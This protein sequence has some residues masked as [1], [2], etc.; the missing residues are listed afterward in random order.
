MIYLHLFDTVSAYTEERLNNYEEPW[1]SLTEENDEVNYNKSEREKLLG[2]ELTFDVT[3][4]GTIYWTLNCQDSTLIPQYQKTIEFKLNDGEWFPIV[5]ATEG[6]PIQVVSGDTIQFRGDNPRYHFSSGDDVYSSFS[7]TTCQFSVKGNIMSLIDSDG[8]ESL[9]AFTENDALAL[10]FAFCTGLTSAEKLILPA[11]GLTNNCYFY[12][13]AYDT[14]LTVGPQLPATVMAS[15]CYEGMFLYDSSLVSAP[16]L[17]ATTLASSCYRN[18]FSGCSSLVSVPDELPAN[19]LADSCYEEMFAGCTS[20]IKVPELPG[21]GMARPA[22]PGCYKNM[23]SGC[24]AI[25]KAPSLPCTLLSSECYYGMFRNCVSLVTPPELPAPR[26]TAS[27]YKEMFQGC[28]SLTTAPE[29]PAT[30][31]TNYC[32][33]HMFA[34]CTNLTT[35]PELPTKSFDS[36]TQYCY[37]GMFK[38]CTSLTTAPELPAT[39]LTSYCYYQMFSGCTSL[40]TSPQAPITLPAATLVEGCYDYMF[41]GC[42]NV[43]EIIC[44]ATTNSAALMP[45]NNWLYGV[46][47]TGTFWDITGSIRWA[48]NASGI[49]AGWTE[50]H[51]NIID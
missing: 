3:S 6:A 14:S 25:T 31:M 11:T 15:N 10:I 41:Y 29:L 12:L 48:R 24:F 26:L 23:F 43:S 19:A 50:M 13:F 33:S 40:D 16:E 44:K 7:G 21:T 46:S 17:P 9:D 37:E 51:I 36:R 30:A 4:N 47:E 1:V 22:A 20:L 32:Y 39:A 2:T 28:T 42:Q 18:M 27:C 38:G 49:P 34:N 45:T 8:F 5:S 35:A